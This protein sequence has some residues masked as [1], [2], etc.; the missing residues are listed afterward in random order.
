MRV[1]VLRV[2][3]D[4]AADFLFTSGADQPFWLRTMPR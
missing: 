2:D 3:L 4:R 1:G